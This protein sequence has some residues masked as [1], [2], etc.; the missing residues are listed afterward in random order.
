MKLLEKRHWRWS[1]ISIVSPVFIAALDVS[2]KGEINF[3]VSVH[4]DGGNEDW[5]F[6]SAILKISKFYCVKLIL[7]NM[8][9]TNAKE[10]TEMVLLLE[11]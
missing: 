9:M 11:Q 4:I 3:Q 2:V 1:V 7:Q 10:R 8:T 6:V 5:E